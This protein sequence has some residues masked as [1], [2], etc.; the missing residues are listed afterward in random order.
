[1]K[2]NKLKDVYKIYLLVGTFSAYMLMSGRD[3]EKEY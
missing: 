2:Y 3:D 1:M